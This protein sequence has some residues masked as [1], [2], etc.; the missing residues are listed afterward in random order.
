MSQIPNHQPSIYSLSHGASSITIRLH[1]CNL[2]HLLLSEIPAF[3]VHCFPSNVF[4]CFLFRWNWRSTGMF[5]RDFSSQRVF[6]FS[7]SLKYYTSHQSFILTSHLFSKSIQTVYSPGRLFWSYTSKL[8]PCAFIKL[9]PQPTQHKA[10]EPSKE[11][12]SLSQQGPSPDTNPG[13][14]A[15]HNTVACIPLVCPFLFSSPLLCQC[16]FHSPRNHP[17]KV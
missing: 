1:L 14:G 2:Y 8:V 7:R 11:I 12:V 15:V 17:S 10:V 16:F 9:V 13:S 6:G 5:A 4:F 3:V